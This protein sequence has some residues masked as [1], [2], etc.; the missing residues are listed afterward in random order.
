MRDETT[1]VVVTSR[2][3]SRHPVLRK[4]LLEH[5]REVTF[6]DEGRRLAGSE[7][8]E[9]LR[10]HQK[11]ITGLERLD[12]ELFRQLPELR[13][14]G[15]FGVGVDMIDLDAM[16]RHGVRLGWAS[17]VNRR[18][19]AELALGL[20]IALLRQIP[21]AHSEVRSGVWRQLTGRELSGRTVGIVGCGQVGKDL[22]KLLAPFHCRVLA[23][24]LHSFPEFYRRH[25]VTP[26]DLDTLLRD[27]DIVT[28]HLDL[29]EGTRN[30]I[31]SERL[32]LM[33]PDTLLINTARGG[34]VDAEAVKERL[35]EG[36]LGGAAFDVFAEEPPE[37]RELLELPNFIG[38]P[39]ISGTT[40]DSVVHLG[41]AAIRGLDNAKLPNEIEG[42]RR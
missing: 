13:V 1:A 8:I 40:E 39:H 25:N 19:V 31:S 18:S 11:A 5:Y 22:I 9:F 3:F 21:T 26:A 6:N 27:S 16:Q 33:K 36:V 2:S 23:Y 37:D 41:R 34:L 15:K 29:N 7:L 10:G 28:L 17:G 20:M 14:I 38:T 42:L 35:K 24:D 4:E 30:I 32:L 12:D